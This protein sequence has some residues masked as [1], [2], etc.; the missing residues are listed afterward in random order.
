MAA[1]LSISAAGCATNITPP[2]VAVLDV[3]LM[4]AGVLDQQVSLVLCVTNPN[5]R[6]LRFSR[7]TFAL[8]VAGA[9]SAEGETTSSIALPP[10]ASVAVPFAVATS[11]RNFGP[12]LA[13][14]VTSGGIDYRVS[15]K[16]TLQSLPVSV[17]YQSSGRLSF[18]EA[19]RQLTPQ[20]TDGVRSAC[21]SPSEIAR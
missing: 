5:D 10:H 11:T 18:D 8:D 2:Q 3:G 13:N 9:R 17:P 14:V 4:R 12:Q 7:A 15:G 21:A 1:L 6:E 19:T 20:P 16:V